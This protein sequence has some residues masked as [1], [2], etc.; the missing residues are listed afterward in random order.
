M[1]VAPPDPGF[2]RKKNYFF[3]YSYSSQGYRWCHK[4]FEAATGGGLPGALRFAQLRSPTATIGAG[5]PSSAQSPTHANK[6]IAQGEK[7]FVPTKK[8]FPPITP[9]SKKR[10]G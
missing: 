9:F 6:A 4:G 7:L 5:N 3:S 10:P 1:A 8:S 2:L